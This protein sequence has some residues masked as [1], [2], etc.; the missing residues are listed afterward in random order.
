[1]RK[2]LGILESS[3]IPVDILLK[4]EDFRKWCAVI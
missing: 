2:V 4:S 1:M 3:H